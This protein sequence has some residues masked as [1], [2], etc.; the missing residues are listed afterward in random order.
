MP[1]KRSAN[2]GSAIERLLVSENAHQEQLSFDLSLSTQMISHMK[3]DRRKMQDDIA[4]ESI[5]LYDNPEY[6]L[7]ILYEFSS[8]FT[9]PVLR[10][11][12]IEQN[13]LALAVHAKRE[14]A[15]AITLME[16][17]G[18][19]LPPS[20]ADREAIQELASQLITVRVVSDNFLKQLQ[21]E[22]KVSVREQ[23]KRLA[24]KWLAV[25]WM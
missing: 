17:S 6:I 10:G 1:I 4:K 7:D 9:S 24:R 13:R 18:L 2:T 15:L 23:L 21:V 12:Q 3:N 20:T 5:A 22:Y 19:E 14:M 25:G 16:S 11:K 8:G